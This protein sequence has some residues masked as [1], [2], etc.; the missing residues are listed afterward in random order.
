MNDGFRDVYPLSLA[1]YHSG[2]PDDTIS[3]GS[4]TIDIVKCLIQAGADVNRP[5]LIRGT[6][7]TP[8]EHARAKSLKKIEMLLL[9]NGAED[10]R[11]SRRRRSRWT[12][13]SQHARAKDARAMDED[14]DEYPANSGRVQ[15][16]SQ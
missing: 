15:C 5:S 12:D 4:E 9:E 8:L 11:P 10:A 7:N 1:I 13:K 16:A 2:Q 14:E 6:W 3:A